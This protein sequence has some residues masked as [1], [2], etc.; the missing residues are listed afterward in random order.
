MVTMGEPARIVVTGATGFIG[1]ALCRHLLD[2]GHPVAIIGRASSHWRIADL[3]ERITFIKGDLGAI[4]AIVPQL[5]AFR[6][7]AIVHLAWD[8]VGGA[9]RNDLRQVDNITWTARLISIAAEAGAETF[10]GVGSQAEYG[11]KTSVISEDA[12]TEPTTL[13]GEAKLSAYRLSKMICAQRGIRFAWGRVFSTYGPGD[14]PRW[15][16]PGLIGQLLNRKRPALTAG[17][18]LWDYLHV[19]DAASALAT[20]LNSSAA[21]GVFNLGSGYAQPLRTTVEVVRDAIDPKL[22]L[23]WGEVPYRSDQVMILQA[24]VSRLQSLGW[25][26][27]V[28][29]T[30]GLRSV[31]HW[32]GA[33]RWIYDQA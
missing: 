21:D 13:Y 5:T 6:P 16:I 17:E 18:Q 4:E 26:P 1:A 28:D 24:D 32:Y 12:E 2:L 8:G 10:V 15:M 22:E 30:D 25:A 23:G 7:D 3:V 14:H 27:Q 29:L 31:A 33:N 11:P 19:N 9:D 20:I